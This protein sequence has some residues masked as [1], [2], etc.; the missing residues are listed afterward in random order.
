MRYIQLL[1]VSMLLTACSSNNQLKPNELVPIEGRIEVKEE[2]QTRVGQGLGDVYRVMPSVIF[3]DHIYA[4]DYLGLVQ[5]MDRFTGDELWQQNLEQEVAAGLGVDEFRVFAA[6]LNG[7]VI[8]LN[9]ETGEI[10]WQANLLSEILAVPQSNGQVVVIQTAD[11]RLLGLSATSG[12][13]I[14]EFS[15]NLPILTLRGTSTPALLGNNLLAGFANGRLAALSAEDG[16]LFWERRIA[17]PQGRTEIERVVDIDGSPVVSAQTVYVTSFN[18]TLRAL[19]TNGDTLW[20]QANS[21]YSSP[22]VIN[23][24]VFVSTNDGQVKAFDAKEGFPIWENSILLRRNLSAPQNLNGFLMVADFEGFVHVFDTETGEVI[25][26]FQVDSKGVRSPMLATDKHL[27]VLGN[28][29]LL[30]SLSVHLNP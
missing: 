15:T 16:T 25:A 6:T 8:A 22:V 3:Q 12:E 28:D 7:D 14:W 9:R 26:R 4:A 13:K 1:V 30:S 5:A 21:S 23:G 18:G 17:R 27:Y 11:A 20:S 19:S 29:G 10:D 24:R 2:W